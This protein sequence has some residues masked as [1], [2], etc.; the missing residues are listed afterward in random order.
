M[1]QVFSMQFSIATTR[2]WA[3]IY[4]LGADFDYVVQKPSYCLI[5][6]HVLIHVSTRRGGL[7]CNKRQE[8]AS[9][10]NDALSGIA[11]SENQTPDG[12]NTTSIKMAGPN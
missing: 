9:N 6:L 2:L 4:P 11:Q 1:R 7:S 5:I 12:C 3:I 10:Y 8:P